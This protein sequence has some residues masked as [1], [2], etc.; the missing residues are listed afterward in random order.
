MIIIFTYKYL[1]DFKLKLLE[2][3]HNNGVPQHL[4]MH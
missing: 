3:I 1:G 4:H 2:L